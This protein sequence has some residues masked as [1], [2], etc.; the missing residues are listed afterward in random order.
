MNCK[1]RDISVSIGL[2]AERCGDPCQAGVSEAGALQEVVQT[3]GCGDH[4]VG[5]IP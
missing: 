5:A 2:H 3:P 4:A 1:E